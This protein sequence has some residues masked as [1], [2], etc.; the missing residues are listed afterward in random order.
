[1]LSRA[2][3]ARRALPVAGRAFSSLARTQRFPAHQGVAIAPMIA[4]RPPVQ[5]RFMAT[6]L[7]EADVTERIMGCLK[8]F[9]KVDPTKVTP[10]SH[11]L[12]DLGLDSLDTVEVVMAFEDE[13]A[14]EI[15]DSDAEKIHSCEEAIKYIAQHPHAK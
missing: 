11:F 2:L 13:F 3:T 12:N 14:I 7:D 6:F 4:L 8:N 1:M 15:P 9:Q 5:C 10:T